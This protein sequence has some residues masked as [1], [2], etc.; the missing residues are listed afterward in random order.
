MAHCAEQRGVSDRAHTNAIRCV[1]W[2]ASIVCVVFVLTL[3]HF[4]SISSQL[5]V[6][7][8]ERNVAAPYLYYTLFI[9]KPTHEWCDIECG[10]FPF[11]L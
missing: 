10:I 8:G 4:S 5:C 11:E 6:N 2:C 9:H 3:V 1:A 7:V